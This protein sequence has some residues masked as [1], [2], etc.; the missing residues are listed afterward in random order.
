MLQKLKYAQK[1]TLLIILIVTL[2]ISLTVSSVLYVMHQS[3]LVQAQA[4]SEQVTN[5]EGTD[6]IE[7]VFN[8]AYFLCT[9]LLS[10]VEQIRTSGN[11]DRTEVIAVEKTLLHN[12]ENIYAV[13]VIYE[14][15]AFDGMDA[16]F[17]GQDGYSSGGAFIPSMYRNEDSIALQPSYVANQDMTFYDIP[18]QT[19]KPYFTEPTIYPI[20]GENVMLVTLVMPIISKDAFIGAISIDI[21][22]TFLQ[23]VIQNIH[24]MGGYSLLITNQGTIVANGADPDSVMKS[25]QEL[26]DGT[27]NIIA[28]MQSGEK[29][30]A[31]AKMALVNQPAVYTFLPFQ[32]KGTDVH[33]GFGTIVQEDLVFSTYTQSVHRVVFVSI[34]VLLLS[35]L[36]VFFVLKKEIRPV[37]IAANHL[38]RFANAD[39]TGEIFHKS[40]HAKDEIGTLFHA[41][42]VLQ[43]S[44]TSI[45]TGVRRKASDSNR[46]AATAQ[47]E[48]EALNTQIDYISKTSHHLAGN[49]EQTA[50]S[51]QEM[52]AYSLRI[53]Q[54]VASIAQ[55]AKNGNSSVT[56]IKQRANHLR[57]TSQESQKI[58]S[59]MQESID[60]KLRDAIERAKA[61]NRI[62]VLAD[63]ILKIANET[64]LLALN[65]TIEAARAGE[66]GKGFAVVADE[67]RRL[68]DDS[69]SVITDV[70]HT[71]HT[72]VH[73]VKD[74]TEGSAKALDFLNQHVVTDYAS[75]SST[76]LHYSQDAEFISDLVADLS[77]TSE[78]ISSS[79]QE[80]IG[81]IEEVSTAANSGG[82]SISEIAEKLQLIHQKSNLAME[83]S[84]SSRTYSCELMQT[85]E[86]IYI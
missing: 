5:Y 31:Y 61:V 41:L 43:E 19:L 59:E 73:A 45:V 71:T 18:K 16:A 34:M 69:R 27:N 54:S 36:I 25:I 35:M 72:V 60:A 51:A 81:A 68:A 22:V 32:I 30:S 2:S 76:G 28:A 37:A 64:N 57:M 53:G 7:K 33:W 26:D 50:S 21:D 82:L 12:H 15:N 9:D 85:V 17:I 24:P 46:S 83:Q 38:Q 74:L 13:N 49:M 42:L 63:A 86:E 84:Q 77:S 58:A 23:T 70:Q 55:K 40:M 66:V 29:Y 20:N 3:S 80:M 78:E 75:F 8:E 52:R 1:I 4:L 67:I 10:T 47:N 79:M 39:F 65:A 6:K 14:P 56:E 48:L 62:D 11:P 44:M